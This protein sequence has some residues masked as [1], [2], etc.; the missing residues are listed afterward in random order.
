M[1]RRETVDDLVELADWSDEKNNER[2]MERIVA[3]LEDRIYVIKAGRKGSMM[4]DV[5][6]V[7]RARSDA[8]L[9]VLYNRVEH[10]EERQLQADLPED[11]ETLPQEMKLLWLRTFRA[12][13]ESSG[14][15]GVAHRAARESVRRT[16]E[17]EIA[18]P[19]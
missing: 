4:D 8:R 7:K 6:E 19:T 9:K 11:L 2:L 13:M 5:C 3:F 12:V 18:Q 17:H 1:I 10:F 14:D 15:S 16:T